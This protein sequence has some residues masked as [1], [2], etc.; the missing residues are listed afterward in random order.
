MRNLVIRSDEKYEYK[1]GQTVRLYN[2]SFS[3]FYK[4][5]HTTHDL[6]NSVR[7][8]PKMFQCFLKQTESN[9]MPNNFKTYSFVSNLPLSSLIFLLRTLTVVSVHCSKMPNISFNLEAEKVGVRADL[10][11][12]LVLAT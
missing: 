4:L 6:S 8:H 5:C 10:Q 9:K 2:F 3:Y 11:I 1:Q 12:K 7:K